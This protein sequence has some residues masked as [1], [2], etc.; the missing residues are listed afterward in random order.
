MVPEPADADTGEGRGAEQMLDA[1][2]LTHL[3]PMGTPSIPPNG[4]RAAST[5][6][7]NSCRL[8]Q[9]RISALLRFLFHGEGIGGL[10]GGVGGAETRVSLWTLRALR[11]GLLACPPWEGAACSK[12]SELKAA[13][14][15]LEPCHLSLPG[16]PR[17]PSTHPFFAKGSSS[18]FFTTQSQRNL[19][20]QTFTDILLPSLLCVMKLSIYPKSF[21]LVCDLK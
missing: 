6:T 21:Q 12:G 14:G 3:L 19:K 10:W 13:L 1:I 20:T 7:H 9:P 8:T 5:S 18:L 16:S 15:G 11:L 4:P 17:Q 2:K